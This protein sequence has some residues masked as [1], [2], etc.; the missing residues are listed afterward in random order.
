MDIN[1]FPTAVGVTLHRYNH[2]DNQMWTRIKNDLNYIEADE[3][4]V[5]VS[6]SQLVH[7]F[8]LYYLNEINKIKSTG[9]EFLHKKVTTPYF[10]YMMCQD[11]SNLQYVKFTKGL[12]KTFSR[13][14]E[15]DGD[16][17]LKFDFKVLSA[18][19]NLYDIFNQNELDIVNP[20]LEELEILE[21][22]V[23]YTRIK[24]IELL[25]RL[26]M[27]VNNEIDDDIPEGSVDPIPLVTSFIDA[28][29]PKVESDNPIV[30]LVTDY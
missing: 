8:D 2:L 29:D 23:P 15:N 17:I 6:T 11:L 9:S 25:D 7:L 20:I 26:D 13:I 1:K 21:E 5:I 10:L 18:T 22:E 3:N 12:D 14:L 16:K 19:I 30:L 24:L 28:I 27:W 4:S